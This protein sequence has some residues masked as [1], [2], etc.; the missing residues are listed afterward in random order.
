MTNFFLKKP[1][2]PIKLIFYINI[3]I[4][5]NLIYFIVISYNFI[6]KVIFSKNLRGFLKKY[7]ILETILKNFSKIKFQ[8]LNGSKATNIK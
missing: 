6:K 4:I 2:H 1:L 5:I 8:I 3:L 7:L